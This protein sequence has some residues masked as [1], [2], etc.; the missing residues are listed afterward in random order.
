MTSVPNLIGSKERVHYNFGEFILR[1]AILSIAEGPRTNDISV[2]CVQIS[3]CTLL[4]LL[5]YRVFT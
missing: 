5:I 3:S 2:S 4:T 1:K